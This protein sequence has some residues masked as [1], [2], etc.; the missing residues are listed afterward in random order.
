MCKGKGKTQYDNEKLTKKC[1][2]ILRADRH[3]NHDDDHDHNHN[4]HPSSRKILFVYF[5]NRGFTVIAY[6]ILGPHN[7]QKYPLNCCQIEKKENPRKSPRD[8]PNS[9]TRDVKGKS[10]TSS[11]TWVFWDAAQKAAH[12]GF[13]MPVGLLATNLYSL[14]LQGSRHPVTSAIC[15]ASEFASFS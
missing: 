6:T 9:A 4:N 7:L 8:P 15:S 14:K 11:S 1:K 5:Y 2:F 10:K 13:D 12:P 3:C